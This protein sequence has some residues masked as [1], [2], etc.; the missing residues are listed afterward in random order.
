MTFDEDISELEEGKES[1]IENV[2]TSKYLAALFRADGSQL[3]DIKTWIAAAVKTTAGKMRN[4]WA[5]KTTPLQ[6]KI[7][8]YCTGVCL[9]LVYGCEAWLL[10]DNTCK[11]LDSME[12]TVRRWSQG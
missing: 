2:W 12:P 11:M 3:A 8:I 1:P 6:L 10:D 5:S 4:V 7:R 9:K